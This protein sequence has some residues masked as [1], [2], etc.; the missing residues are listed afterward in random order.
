MNEQEKV[1]IPKFMAELVEYTK[2]RNAVPADILGM[3]NDYEPHELNLPATLN[4]EK[5][6][7]YFSIACH[8]YDYEKAC[9]VGYEVKE[10]DTYRVKIGN[11]YF[12]KFQSNGCLVSPH[13]IDGIMD[14]ESKQDAERVANTIGGIVVPANEN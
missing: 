8:R 6:S 14:F 1:K 12:I 7:E 9:F 2:N 13:E 4:L 5:L 11:G 10:T 3:F